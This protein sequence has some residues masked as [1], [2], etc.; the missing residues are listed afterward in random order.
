M[1]SLLSAGKV[2]ATAV[3][4][5]SGRMQASGCLEESHF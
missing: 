5:E 4:S 1:C 3:H 2:G